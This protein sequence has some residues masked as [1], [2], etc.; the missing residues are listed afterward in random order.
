LIDSDEHT[1]VIGGTV[2][3]SE[4][5]AGIECRDP[6]TGVW[7]KGPALPHPERTGLTAT[8]RRRSRSRRGRS[9]LATLAEHSRFAHSVG[10]SSCAFARSSTSSASRICQAAISPR[11]S[12]GTDVRFAGSAPRQSARPKRCSKPGAPSEAWGRCG[13]MEDSTLR[14][15]Q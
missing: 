5:A 7:S 10:R 2:S 12:A 4:E 1:M 13:V 3:G 8:P 9:E 11:C 14:T 15:R 6:S